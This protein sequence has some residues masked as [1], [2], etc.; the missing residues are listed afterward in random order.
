MDTEM[1]PTLIAIGGT[2]SGIAVGWAGRARTIKQDTVSEATKDATLQADM[3]YLKRG[4]DDMR[5]KM[6]IHAQ[7]YDALAEMAIRMDESIKS[8][9]KRIDKLEGTG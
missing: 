9:H 3:A 8:A 6:D 4:I 2:V 5:V 7:R 1:V